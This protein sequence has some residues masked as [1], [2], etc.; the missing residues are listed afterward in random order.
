MTSKQN[1]HSLK[2]RA[3]QGGKEPYC[4][5]GAWTGRHIPD[6][7]GIHHTD[8]AEARARREYSIHVDD[9]SDEERRQEQTRAKTLPAKKA[10]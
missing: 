9:A 2:Y 3:T 7:R 6:G 5:C 1:S 8:A 10:T 4:I